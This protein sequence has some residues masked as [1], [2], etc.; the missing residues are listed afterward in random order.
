ML[1]IERGKINELVLSLAEKTTVYAPVKRKDGE[2]VFKQIG[3]NEKIDLNY[4]TT[5]LPIKK[6]FLPP[7]EELF[8]YDKNKKRIPYSK[9][10]EKFIIFGLNL[11]DT[12]AL[13]QLDEIM[14]FPKPDYYYFNKR[15][16]STIIC[17]INEKAPLPRVG[18]DLVL[19]KINPTKYKAITL[20]SQGKKLVKNP[21]FRKVSKFPNNSEVP[22]PQQPR[23]SPGIMPK[24]RKLLL[25]PELLHDAVKW[26]WKNYPK[27]WKSL[28]KKCLGCGICTYV[29]P[30]CYCFSTNDRT[31][32]NGKICTRCRYWTACTLPE[33]SQ[34][35]GG[36]NFHKTLKE[37]Y[38]NWYYHK[39]VR[40]YREFGKSQCTACGRCKNY[41]PAGIDV[42]K[43][44]VEIT[45][46]FIS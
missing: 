2:C 1:I 35:T 19:E 32:L 10:W 8:K 18:V 23:Q 29:C 39:F 46:K 40:A 11:R 14:N 36:H 4:S 37:R 15:K 31:N 6:F 28:E 17:L 22:P 5:I 38:Y 43:V 20:T 27:I 24:L 30:L 16:A 7:E 3:A 26:S 12:E 41:C 33:F 25:D 44:L 34:I 45:N 21:C 42:E 13:I 9:R